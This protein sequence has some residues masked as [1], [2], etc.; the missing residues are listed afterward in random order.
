MRKRSLLAVM[1]C[2]VLSVGVVACGGDEEA[3]TPTEPVTATEE[4][5]AAEGDAVA[6]KEIFGANCAGCHTLADAGA[7]G[8]AGP[9]LDDLKPDAARVV[10]KVQTGGGAMPA[11][12]NDGTL[13]AT[14]IANVAAYVSSATAG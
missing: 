2:A 10:A 4:P 12:G 3:A 8:A 9:N 7:T 14:Q 1:L 13:D 5:A 11:F 6:G